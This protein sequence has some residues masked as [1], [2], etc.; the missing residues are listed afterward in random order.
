MIKTGELQT[1]FVFA[2][3]GLRYTRFVKSYYVKD[4]F[5]AIK[6]LLNKWNE[7]PLLVSK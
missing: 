1:R 3:T 2:K 6:G 5:Y 7:I 4:V